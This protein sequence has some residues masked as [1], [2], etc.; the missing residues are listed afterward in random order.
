MPFRS[1]CVIWACIAAGNV[2]AQTRLLPGDQSLRIDRVPLT[3]DTMLVL[4]SRSGS[5]ERLITT[6]IRRIERTSAGAG[7]LLRLVQRYQSPDG[8]WEIDTIELSARTLALQ[9]S[10]EVGTTT[11][12]SLRF[13]GTHLT[14]TF[15]ANGAAP[16]PIAAKPGPF[17]LEAAG[18][19]FIPAFPLE[20]GSTLIFPEMEQTNLT[21]RPATL[22]VDSVSTVVTADGWVGCLV[23]HGPGGATL[24]IARGDGHLLRERW[25]E[26]DGTV[27]WKL[28]RRDA[29]FRRERYLIER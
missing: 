8:D 16:T 12:R 24:W 17:F 9:R 1:T 18:E 22:Q 7:D 20:V 19:A 29:P 21:V 6:L 10:I 15:T 26:R 3:T 11:A 5:D 25:V 2:E 28:P 14:G 13:D 27:V 4:T 23:A